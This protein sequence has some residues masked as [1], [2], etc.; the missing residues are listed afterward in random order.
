M[1]LSLRLLSLATACSVCVPFTAAA[2]SDVPRSNVN[3]DA[4]AYVRE[5]GIVTGYADGTFGPGKTINRAEFVTILAKVRIQ[6]DKEWLYRHPDAPRG[7]DSMCIAAFSDPEIGMPFTDVRAT[8]WYAHNVCFAWSHQLVGGYP[9][10]TFRPSR[11]I[12]FA[13]AAK[14]IGATFDLPITPT[15]VWYEGSVRA[16]ADAH[17]IPTSVTALEH[18]L[19]RGEMAEIIYRLQTGTV[20][21]IS[22]TYDVLVPGQMGT[23]TDPEGLFRLRYPLVWDITT[24]PDGQTEIHMT[25]GSSPT[26]V[27]EAYLRVSVLPRCLAVPVNSADTV[28]TVTLG[29]RSFTAFAIGDGAMGTSYT[30]LTFFSALSASR[31]LVLEKIIGVSNVMQETD[32]DQRD[33]A[34]Q[35]SA[36]EDALKT[37]IKSIVFLR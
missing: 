19:T 20:S 25:T 34:A 15:S 10:R 21:K 16:L 17:A 1:R 22:Q 5:H 12:S 32:Q 23:Y 14:I 27:S 8:D 7:D 11:S 37:V 24:T 29:G 9:D 2:F 4:I 26:F 3:A 36:A 28:Q 35:K 31:C 33:A 30:T 13:E 18:P 6:R